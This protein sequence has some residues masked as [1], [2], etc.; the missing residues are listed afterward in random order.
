[1]EPDAVAAIRLSLLRRLGHVL[2]FDLEEGEEPA[3]VP[4]QP[5]ARGE[6]VV[7]EGLAI[8]HAQQSDAESPL[9]PIGGAAVDGDRV[10]EG[11]QDHWRAVIL[12]ERQGGRAEQTGGRQSH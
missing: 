8:G 3:V 9:S 10:H 4:P 12:G 1:M 2:V 11:D 6:A 7:G 5:V